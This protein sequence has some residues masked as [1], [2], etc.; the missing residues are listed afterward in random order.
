MTIFTQYS[1]KIKSRRPLNNEFRYSFR[2]ICIVP[3]KDVVA[4]SS[5]MSYDVKSLT[6]NHLHVMTIA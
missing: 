6:G 3:S 4:F 1:K 2:A 5:M